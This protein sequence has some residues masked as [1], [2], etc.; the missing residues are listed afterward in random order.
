VC[1]ASSPF[2]CFILAVLLAMYDDNNNNNEPQATIPIIAPE[3]TPENKDFHFL[4]YCWDR[5][6]TCH[7]VNRSLNGQA[8]AFPNDAV[9]SSSSSRSPR[10]GHG[11]F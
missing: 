3:P 2:Y 11:I 7:N 10:P 4:N 1:D 9:T 8:T 5:N 6:F